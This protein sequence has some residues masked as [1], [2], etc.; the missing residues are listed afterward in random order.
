MIDIR[1]FLIACLVVVTFLAANVETFAWE[2]SACGGCSV[3]DSH[4]D[5]WRFYDRIR[6][7]SGW[8]GNY[9]KQD[10][11]C[12][13]IHYKRMAL[14]GQNNSWVD[15]SDIHY[16]ISHGGSRWDAYYDKWLTAVLFE[17][18]TNLVPSEARLAWGDTDLEWIAFRNC[19]LLNNTSKGYWANA[20]NRLHLLLGFKT[21]SSKHNNFGK[22]WANKMKK[23]TILWWTI[24]GQT[25]TQA[26]FNATDATQPSGTTARVLA[27][28]HN[29]YNDH[30]WGNGYVSPDP[31]VDNWYWWWDHTAGSPEYLAVNNLE[32]MNVYEVV[33]RTVDERYVQQIGTA[34]GLTGEVG[35]LCESLVMADLRDPDSPK[36]LE[37]SKTTGHFY[38]HDD[39]KLFLFN[40]DVQQ[41]PPDQAVERSESFLRQYDLFPA[42]EVGEATA[43]F[44]TITEEGRDKGTVRQTFYQNTNAV[45]A[46][47]LPGDPIGQE[48]VSVAGAGARLK[49]YLFDKGL[50]MGAMG[51][52]REVVKIGEI[53]VFKDGQTAWSFFDRF[54]EKIAITPTFVEYDKA[55]PNYE[56]ATQGYYELPGETYQTELIPVWIFEVDYYMEDRLVLTADTFIPAANSYL[57]PVVTIIR[58]KNGESFNYGE[59]IVFDCQVEEEFGTPP[60]S[61]RW[62]SN[63]DGVLSTMQS[64]ASSSLSVHCPDRSCDCRPLPHTITVT[65]T[66]AKG[67]D[68]SHSVQIM[69][70]GDC[71]ECEDCAD[72]NSDNAVDMKDLA[73]WANRY[74]TQ[75]GHGE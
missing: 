31:P 21:N 60:Y 72:L 30:L 69:V 61:F 36:V 28:V 53:P 17:D 54:G 11:N 46:R 44:D 62:E 70:I 7:F 32:T 3:P 65:A 12:K 64:F 71:G 67:F 59:T 47:Q 66:D 50:V 48:M 20:M 74:L 63:V 33:P 6:S 10:T 29:N 41:F 18:G 57:P 38:F 22:I 68:S 1:K 23:T 42:N 37:V 75:S 25:V 13:E 16:H 58:P 40:P 9:Y 26:W 43:E 27:E 5:A 4:P 8:T 49:V 35:D 73:H 2:V 55:V 15:S 45:F 34:F 19:T 39:G 24:P 51:K 56:T 52:W 14:G